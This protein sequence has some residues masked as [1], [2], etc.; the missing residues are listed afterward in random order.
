MSNSLTIKRII[1]FWIDLIVLGI[2]VCVIGW[3]FIISYSDDTHVILSIILGCFPIFL[4]KD[5][6]GEASIGKRFFGLYVGNQNEPIQPVKKYKLILRNM[7]CIIWP[8]EGISLLITGKR[9]GDRITST[10]VYS[11]QSSDSCRPPRNNPFF[12]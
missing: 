6:I 1:S 3:F 5:I 8:I 10:T 11:K 12:N 2:I 7:T 4:F 9:I